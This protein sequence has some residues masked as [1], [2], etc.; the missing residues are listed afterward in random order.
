V[1]SLTATAESASFAKTPVLRITP[2][3]RWWA[4]PFGELWSYRELL[5]FFVWRDIKIRYKQTAI[6]AAWA[7]LQPLLAMTVFTLFFGKLAHI[8]SEGLPYQVF[9]YAGLLPWMYFAASLQNATNTIVE[10]QRVITKVYFPRLVLPLSAV[11]S[12]LVDFGIS[13]LIFVLMMVYYHIRPTMHILWLPAFLLLGVLTALGVGLWLSALN[14]IYRDVRYVLPFMIQ[15]WLFASPVIYPPELM[16]VKWRWL[17]GLNPMA[18]VIEGFRWSLAGRGDPPGR[19]ILV[20]SG[21]VLVILLGGLA[22]FQKMESTIA[23]V[24]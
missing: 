13:F 8:P 15:L 14:A 5:Y 2:P 20:S 7:V 24:A 1:T 18:G 22:F 9:V 19:L 10:N 12:G 21:I 16:S 23:D 11:F 4:L 3:S 6:G 17:F